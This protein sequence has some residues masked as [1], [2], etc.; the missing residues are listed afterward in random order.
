[1]QTT[2][3]LMKASAGTSAIQCTAFSRL[4]NMET[5][6]IFFDLKLPDLEGMRRDL[7]TALMHCDAL[8]QHEHPPPCGRLAPNRLPRVSPRAIIRAGGLP[9][10]GVTL[11]ST[12]A[13][14]CHLTR[15]MPVRSTAFSTPCSPR[16]VCRSCSTRIAM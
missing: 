11:G 6:F 15:S 7:S 5:S 9:P 3:V 10:T 2:D 12:Q 4:A 13:T 8:L 16:V 1:V 14:V